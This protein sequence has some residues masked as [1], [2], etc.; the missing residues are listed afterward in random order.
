MEGID[1]N[2]AQKIA[3]IIALLTFA[4]AGSAQLTD[5][6]SPFGSAAPLIVK[7][8]VSVSTFAAGGLSIWLAFITGQGAQINAV[9]AMPGVEHITV[10]AKANET[11]AAIAVDPTQPKIEATAAA[12]TAV[13]HT[14]AAG[15]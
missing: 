5:I 3:L 11:L 12:A 14:A 1:M 6:F 13:Q 7:E 4:G 15:V 9:L 10:N 2:K 8:I